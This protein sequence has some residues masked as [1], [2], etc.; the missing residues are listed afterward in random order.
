MAGEEPLQG[1]FK[2]FHYIIHVSRLSI[3]WPALDPAATQ[4]DARMR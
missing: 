4:D 1:S 3:G 2:N